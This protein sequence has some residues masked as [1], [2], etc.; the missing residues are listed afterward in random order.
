LVAKDIQ[1]KMESV[2]KDKIDDLIKKV[3]GEKEFVCPDVPE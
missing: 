1:E 2:N 3:F